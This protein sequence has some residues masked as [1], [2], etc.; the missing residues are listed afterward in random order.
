MVSHAGGAP[1]H[2]HARKLAE[3]RLGRAAG[4]VFGERERLQRAARDIA[5]FAQPG[6]EV[7]N[8]ERD[9]HAERLATVGPQ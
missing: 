3:F 6:C 2:L 1:A 5:S 9:I 8:G 4:P 7:G